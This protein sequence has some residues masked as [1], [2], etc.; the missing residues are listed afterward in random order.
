M[1]RLDKLERQQA[2][3]EQELFEKSSRK[4]FK[5]PF[6]AKRLMKQSL[7]KQDTVLVQYLTQKYQMQFKLCK[8]V[9]GNLIVVNNK[10]HILNPKYSW[11]YGKHLW[12]IVREIDRMPVS[13]KDY[14]AVK[15]RR[16]DTEA[17]V[18]LIKAVLG[19]VQ[20]PSIPG[21]K[22]AWI[23]IG[24]IVVAVIILFMFMR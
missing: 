9:Q 24:I 19:A 2:I 10:V 6:K 15:R 7:K 22:S 14:D 5:L 1:S 13:N 20:K 23:I 11:R 21:G 3:L 4:K 16:D 8:I 17:D 18:P 12:Y